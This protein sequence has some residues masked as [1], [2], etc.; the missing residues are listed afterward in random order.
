MTTLTIHPSKT[1]WNIREFK[2]NMELK[3][4]KD[5]E[6]DEEGG[7]RGGR[8]TRREEDEEGGGRGGRRTRRE[9]DEEGGWQ[10]LPPFAR[11]ASFLC[12]HFWASPRPPRAQT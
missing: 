8:R 11:P 10:F 7:G 6:E 12:F 1:E 2:K 9:E 5:G 3:A 4:K